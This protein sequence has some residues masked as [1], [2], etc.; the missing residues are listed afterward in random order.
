M[1]SLGYAI[2]LVHFLLLAILC[3]FGLHRLS[4]VFRWLRYR[5]RDIEPPQRFDQ[6]PTLTIQVP[7]FNERFVAE[8]IVSAVAATD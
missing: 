6:Y 8:R 1:L 5:S 4:M 3:L 7:L 2:L